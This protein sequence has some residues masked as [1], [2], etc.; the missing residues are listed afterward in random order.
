M[1]IT[2]YLKYVLVFIILIVLQDTVMWLFAI[3]KY[4]ITPDLVIILV[5]YVGYMRGHITGMISGFISGLIL[6]IL[7]GSFIGLSAVSY[8]IAGFIAGYFNIQ[9]REHSTKKNS[10]ITIIFG[11]TLIA[12]LIFFAVYFQGSAIPFWEVFLKYIITTTIYT[13]VFGFIFVLL[14]NRFDLKRNF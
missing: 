9:I 2:S 10:L 4:N 6:D 1:F 8:C 3:S 5:I 7:S 11:C 13:T 12:Y 14:F